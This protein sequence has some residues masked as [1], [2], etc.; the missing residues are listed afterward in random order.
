MA[1]ATFAA[2]EAFVLALD[3]SSRRSVLASLVEGSEA[4]YE[5][6]I[7]EALHSGKAA[8]PETK[9]LT[10]RYLQAFPRSPSAQRLELRRT[11]LAASVAAEGSEEQRKAL[12]DIGEKVLGLHF[13]HQSQGPPTRTGAAM[14]GSSLTPAAPS[15]LSPE[16]LPSPAQVLERLYNGDSGLLY[17]GLPVSCFR[18][19]QL[20]RL[21]SDRHK[22]LSIFL[23]SHQSLLP[24]LSSNPSFLKAIRSL[25]ISQRAKQGGMDWAPKEILDFLTLQQL[26]LL[27]QQEPELQKDWS[28]VQCL[29]SRKF[30][31]YL[32]RDAQTLLNPRQRRANLLE[33]VAFLDGCCPVPAVDRA[34]VQEMQSSHRGPAMTPG[35]LRVRLLYEILQLGMQLAV[36]DKG[37]FLRYLHEVQTSPRLLDWPGIFV[38]SDD[39]RLHHISQAVTEAHLRHFILDDTFVQ[40]LKPLLNEASSRLALNKLRDERCLTSGRPLGHNNADRAWLQELAEQSKVEL[41]PHNPTDFPPDAEVKLFVR[42]KNVSRLSVRIYEINAENY[43]VHQQKPFSSDINLDGVGASSEQ[44]FS[45]AEAPVF[46]HDEELLFPALTGRSGLF[47]LDLVG[48]GLRAR[49]VIRKGTLSLIHKTSPVGHVA[50]V[51]GP[52]REVVQQGARLYLAG[53]WYESDVSKAGRIIIPYGRRQE[54][55]KVVISGLGTAQFSDFVRQA[56]SYELKVSFCLLPESVIMGQKAKLLVRPRLLCCGRRCDPQLLR[57]TEVTVAMRTG[58][59]GIPVVRSFSGFGVGAQEPG[60]E[61][62]VPPRL[63]SLDVTFS[64]EVFNHSQ[65]RSEQHCKSRLWSVGDH[66]DSSS[67]LCEIYLSRSEEGY[68]VRI[69]GKDGEPQKEVPCHIRLN[70]LIDFDA[71]RLATDS[72][73][74]IKLGALDHV[75]GLQVSA[76]G[77]VR[78]WQLLAAG[79]RLGLS[80]PSQVDALEGEEI[81]LPCPFGYS[82]IEPHLLSL[83]ELCGPGGAQWPAALKT[84]LVSLEAGPGEGS[85]FGT[86]VIRGLGRGQYRLLLAGDSGEPLESIIIQVHR[87]R[88]WQGG[89]Y[90]LRHDAIVENSERPVVLSI[91]SAEA[92][93]DGVWASVAGFGPQTRVHMFAFNFLPPKLPELLKE[94]QAVSHEEYTIA[95]FPFQ[96]W[97]N[98]YQSGISLGSENSYVLRRRKAEAQVGNLL[99]KPQLL[100]HPRELRDTSFEKEALLGAAPMMMQME[101]DHWGARGP[102]GA[103]AMMQQQQACMPSMY[104]GSADKK[105]GRLVKRAA[106]EMCVE[107]SADINAFQNFLKAEPFVALNL[108][109]SVEGRVQVATDLSAFS[110]VLIV[111]ADERSV[112][113]A[114]LTR[115]GPRRSEPPASRGLALKCGLDASL[116]CVEQRVAVALQPGESFDLADQASAEWRTIDSLERLTA[117]FRAVNPSVSRLLEELGFSGWSSMDREAKL[118]LWSKNVCH[119]LNIFIFFKD[120]EFFGEVVEPFLSSKMEHDVVD[121]F[122]L[123]DRL[124]VRPL[125]APARFQRLNP[126]EQVLVLRLMS[127]ECPGECTQLAHVIASQAKASGDKTKRLAH[128]NALLDSVLSLEPCKQPDEWT[129]LDAE[130][131]QGGKGGK[132]GKGIRGMEHASFARRLSSGR[133]SGSDMED[134]EE[135]AGIMPMSA[136]NDM[137][138]FCANDVQ[139]IA[140]SREAESWTAPE[141]TKEYAETF[142]KLGYKPGFVVNDFWAAA[143]L[144]AVE[145]EAR[146]LLSPDFVHATTCLPEVAGAVALMDLPFSAA[147]H[148]LLTRDGLAASF[149]AQSPCVFVAREIVGVPAPAEA[150]ARDLLVTVRIFKAKERED[151]SQDP[152]A[153]REFLVNEP[154]CLQV[155]VTNVSPKTLTCQILVQVPQGAL[156]LG[157]ATYTRAYPQQLSAFACCRVAVHFYFPRHGDFIGAP[158]CCSVDGL[159]VATSRSV[160]YHVVQE[161][162]Q[163]EVRSFSDV[164]AAGESAVLTFL[165]ERDLVGGEMNFTFQQIYPLLSSAAFFEAAVATLR[166]RGLFDRTVWSYGFWHGDSRACKE[167]LEVEDGIHRKLGPFFESQMVSVSPAQADFKHLEYYPLFNKRAHRLVEAGSAAPILNAQLKTTYEQFLRSL[168]G[169]AA[170]GPEERLR[171]SYYLLCQDRVHEA[172][173]QFQAADAQFGS[174]SRN[175]KLQ[176]DY[177]A[178]YL[179]LFHASGQ[180]STARRIA[181]EHEECHHAAWRE[182]FEALAQVLAEIDRPW[183]GDAGSDVAGASQAAPALHAELRSGASLEIQAEGLAEFSIRLYR[184]ELDMLFSRIPFL[185]ESG[186][187]PDFSF[188]KPVFEG[189]ISGNTTTWQIPEEHRRDDLAIELSAGSLKVF[190]LYFAS[191]LRVSVAEQ[192]GYLTASSKE[193]RHLPAVYV[194]VSARIGGKDEFFK[195][196]YTDLRG[197]FDYASLSGEPASVQRFSLLV[198]AGDE[199][200]VVREAAPPSGFAG[201]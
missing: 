106:A 187:Q 169:K 83:V 76:C 102:P 104:H 174:I 58:E 113:H 84:E 149:V 115:K 137:F 60:V 144:N 184:V 52:D 44:E 90:I 112:A 182:R 42:L 179:D 194:K 45:Y 14:G 6:S 118:A 126:L 3:D 65:K 49:A 66:S 120:P 18:E 123:R 171:L 119:E 92:L 89:E 59:E 142:Y 135:E 56:E 48:S 64:A 198:M 82:V 128:R 121:N 199:G 129:V 156:P 167:I 93:H 78:S 158:V 71:P 39:F 53:R 200:G 111:A 35:S 13:N 63:K 186:A 183:P 180:L 138:D 27:A 32:D 8:A 161:P 98:L 165:S 178:A 160:P 31:S 146:A 177:M 181:K 116:A 9:H 87:G 73:G 96:Q 10:D 125:L 38:A 37:L 68:E 173:A 86:L 94:L 145:P 105:E 36:F 23:R 20:D 91:P 22:N 139:A 130:P 74:A 191:T 154:Y 151:A 193:G 127:T 147:D 108:T 122:L 110:M 170:L 124:S 159:V 189:K 152:R 61:F 11:F 141:T 117:F 29:V 33:V 79:G 172:C 77:L 148:S 133:S 197:R 30:W 81:R 28:L 88:R 16:A 2:L 162:D 51:L 15:V 12:K 75:T 132:G 99:K 140:N 50:Y 19:L 114:L 54:S 62:L 188:V 168:A 97:K 4:W 17:G 107:Q 5:L 21:L 69:L 196:G 166:S 190:N 163:V 150:A 201:R 131:S 101:A 100:L 164:L 143:A 34:A 155:V 175:M 67:S 57:K 41:L 47:V 55:V 80:L 40:E 43:Y 70:G 192:H 7:L 46:E 1:S 195:D 26:E 176:R 109:P 95:T 24:L 157:P 153:V 85:S 103:P 136:S 185:R 134:C 25:L 72:F